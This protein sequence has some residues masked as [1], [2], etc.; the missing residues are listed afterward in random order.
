MYR[1]LL[2]NEFTSDDPLYADGVGDQILVS[3]GIVM[4]N[5]E[6]FGREWIAYCFAYL[7][8]FLFLCMI[9]SAACLTYFRM[10]PKITATPDVSATEDE[11]EKKE[12]EGGRRCTLTDTAFIPVDLSFK[13]VSYEVKS[14]TGSDTLRL[15]NN[16]SGVFRAG[17]MCAL[18]GEV[19]YFTLVSLVIIE[20]LIAF[21]QFVYT[22]SPVWCRED[23]I[24]SLFLVTL[25]V[26][27]V[28]CVSE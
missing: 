27:S 3:A 18:M 9:T 12:T 6:P 7:L 25:N 15:L 10:E 13:N 21:I 11:K 8:P 26:F 16:V 24:V 5:G 17:R 22:Y 19:R 20:I 1:A 28:Q 23:N 2:L 14:S 4:P